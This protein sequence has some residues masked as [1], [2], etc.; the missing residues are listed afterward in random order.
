M[1]AGVKDGTV[2]MTDAVDLG[3]LSMITFEPR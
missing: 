1:N 3:T 2:H